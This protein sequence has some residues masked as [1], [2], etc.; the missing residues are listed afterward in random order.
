MSLLLIHRELFY[1]IQ[2]ELRSSHSNNCGCKLRHCD[3]TNMRKETFKSLIPKRHMVQSPER[4]Q[5]YIA[6]EEKHLNKISLKQIEKNWNGKWQ[7][8]LFLRVKLIFVDF[9]TLLFKPETTF[10]IFVP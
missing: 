2:H 5:E 1:I 3:Q 4:L 9:F 8:L 7:I 6:R 10:C